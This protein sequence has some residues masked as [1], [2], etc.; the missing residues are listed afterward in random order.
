MPGSLR[1][2]CREHYSRGRLLG[3]GSMEVRGQASKTQKCKEGKL[4]SVVPTGRM[5][6]ISFLGVVPA[7]LTDI[8]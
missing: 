3:M 4:L 5:G 8:Q 2:L 6:A 7:C 1:R